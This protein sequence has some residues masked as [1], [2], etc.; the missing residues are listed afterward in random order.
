[1]KHVCKELANLEFLSAK[2]KAAFLF[3]MRMPVL[4]IGKRLS[5]TERVQYYEDLGHL[6]KDPNFSIKPFVQICAK[7]RAYLPLNENEA[8]AFY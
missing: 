2:E 1:M 5:D 3:D 4:P 6:Y 7:C 8:L